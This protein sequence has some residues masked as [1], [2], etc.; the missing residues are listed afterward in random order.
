MAGKWKQIDNVAR[1]LCCRLMPKA[2]I[3]GLAL[4]LVL[5]GSVPELAAQAAGSEGA[6]L[7]GEAAHYA[8]AETADLASVTVGAM[9]RPEDHGFYQSVVETMTIAQVNYAEANEAH[10][11]IRI[12]KQVVYW[13]LGGLGILL[14]LAAVFHWLVSGL[15]KRDPVLKFLFRQTMAAKDPNELYN[16]FNAMIKHGYNLSLKASS[17]DTIRL[18]LPDAA[19]AAQ[20]ADIMNYMESHA[21]GPDYLKGRIRGIYKLMT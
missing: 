8:T 19:L 14:V 18:G 1:H 12:R 21:K 11:V 5:L 6:A 10:F 7:E 3:L 2:K 4:G 20:V 16:R 17:Q 9:P 15:K 13:V